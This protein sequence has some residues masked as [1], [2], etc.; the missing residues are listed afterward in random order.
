MTPSLSF[1]QMPTSDHDRFA[2][3]YSPA[4]L[5][6]HSLALVLVLVLLPVSFL[7]HRSITRAPDRQTLAQKR[8][9]QKQWMERRDL[10]FAAA[11]S[12]GS[13]SGSGPQSTDRLQ[14]L[15]TEPSRDNRTDEEIAKVLEWVRSF[16]PLPLFEGGS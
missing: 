13:D 8:P 5:S 1:K 9:M 16:F 12:T 7:V 10:L 4:R 11:I 15:P 14:Q 6:P 3:V 2:S